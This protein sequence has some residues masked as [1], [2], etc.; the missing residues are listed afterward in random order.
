MR[1]SAGAGPSFGYCSGA[2]A[3][4]AGYTQLQNCNIVPMR[5]G[6]PWLTCMEASTMRRFAKLLAISGALLAIQT[7]S[8]TA[9]AL[10]NTDAVAAAILACWKPP[11]G[12][13]GSSVTMTFSFRRD[14]SIFGHPRPR[15]VDVT[16]DERARRRFI[17]AAIDAVERCAPLDFTPQ[18]AEGIGGKVFS[19]RFASPRKR[20]FA[21]ERYAWA[22]G[23]ADQGS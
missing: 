10:G 2:C 13:E 1:R 19:M 15:Q 9:D 11:P 17:Y 3:P 18:F 21:G 14:G 23:V 16:G 22:Q 20:V 7:A 5:E 4:A 8:A 12:F 6:A